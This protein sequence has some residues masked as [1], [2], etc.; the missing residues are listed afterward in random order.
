[1]PDTDP[2]LCVACGE[3]ASP[4]ADRHVLPRCLECALW[5]SADQQ[6]QLAERSGPHYEAWL[7]TQRKVFAD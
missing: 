1:M 5:E 7:A 4:T 6:R 3:P 2:L